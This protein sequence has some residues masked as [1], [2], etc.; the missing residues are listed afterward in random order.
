MVIT[1]RCKIKFAIN[2]DYFDEVKCIVAPLDSSEVMFGN[3]YLSERDVTFYMGDN[4]YILVK[5]GK[6]GSLMIT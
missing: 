3:P 5:C 1:R 2:T 4:K 6:D